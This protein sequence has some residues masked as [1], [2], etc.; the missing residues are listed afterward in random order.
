[1]V[2]PISSAL[3]AGAAA[4]IIVDG[5]LYPIDTVKSRLQSAQG[6][7]KA[8]GFKNVYRGIQPVL[9]G[10]MP[11]SAFFFISYETVKAQLEET[12][13]VQS[14]GSLMKFASHMV[15]ASIGE[16][17]ACTIRGPYEV[18][19]IR[20]QTSISKKFSPLSILS[21]TLAKE[22]FF[23]LYRGFWSTVFRDSPFSAIQFPI[24]EGLKSAH[25]RRLSRS[26]GAIESA[27]YGSIAAAI[28]A[29]VTT[30]VDVAKT[31]IVLAGQTDKMASGS[32]STAL[33]AIFAERG[34]RGLFAGVLPRTIWMGIGGFIYLG[35]YDKVKKVLD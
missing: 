9:L 21:K 30:P 17:M 8:G 18:V 12:G 32:M 3:I 15:A 19:K 14:S 5:L 6:F 27:C 34:V 7:R 29:I 16:F 20:S 4:G 2:V 28:A 10:S 11:A 13:I 33:S 23:G 24:W 31:R 1:M 25:E 35:A 22:G 26:A